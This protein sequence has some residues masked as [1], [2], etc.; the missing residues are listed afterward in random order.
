M[1]RSTVVAVVSL[2]LAAPLSAQEHTNRW[3]L[4]ERF[5]REVWL[6]PIRG[7]DVT[8]LGAGACAHSYR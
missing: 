5:I 7:I 8:V 3:E 2:F 6:H 1:R 4:T